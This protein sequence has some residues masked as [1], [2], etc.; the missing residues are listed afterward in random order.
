MK[1]NNHLFK[2]THIINPLNPTTS[3]TSFQSSTIYKHYNNSYH[4][5]SSSSLHNNRKSFSFQTKPYLNSI[6]HEKHL[7][8]LSSPNESTL[9]ASTTPSDIIP[10]S[11]SDITFD[12]LLLLEEKIISLITSIKSKKSSTIFHSSIEWLNCYIVSSLYNCNS[13]LVINNNNDI[14]N[15]LTY[16]SNLL[17]YTNILCYYIN[18]LKV[19]GETN[20]Y[21]ELIIDMM[22]Y[23]H[24]IFLLICEY[25]IYI[26]VSLQIVSRNEIKLLKQLTKQI[27][28]YI[29][30]KNPQKLQTSTLI[31]NEIKLYSNYLHNHIDTIIKKFCLLKQIPGINHLEMFSLF[32]NIQY[33][34]PNDMHKFFM[35]NFFQNKP[36]IHLQEYKTS[37]ENVPFLQSVSNKKYTL[38]LDL[39]ETLIHFNNN[40]INEQTNKKGNI[41]FRPFLYEFLE[42]AQNIFELVIYTVATKKYADPIINAIEKGNNYFACRLYREHCVLYKG[43]YVKD[44]SLLGRDL[45]KIIIIDD[46]P[47]NF[48]L[49]KENGIAIK[50][51]WGSENE[52]T[53]DFVLKNLMFILLNIIK[54][55]SNDLRDG[56]QKYKEDIIEYIS[57]GIGCYCK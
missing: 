18:I 25:L 44:I 42:Q 33:K 52:S 54:V 14:T 32:Y 46:K 41:H 53:N 1:S 15:L 31:L 22:L 36:Q 39:D 3:N 23:H 30:H 57:K 27:T 34:S 13:I 40:I 12:S 17:M 7:S 55:K 20:T 2:S 21:D 11:K 48:I 49:Q 35:N 8:T 45:D 37:S 4:P 26:V 38:V 43:L 56:I 51:Y 28:I 5:P 9:T 10:H 29:H 6:K 16:T 47:Y 24:R 19:H 50:P